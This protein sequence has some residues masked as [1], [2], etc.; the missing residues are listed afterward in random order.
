MSRQGRQLAEVGPD[1][2]VI[3]SSAASVTLI[4]YCDFECPYCRRATPVVKHLVARYA[5]GMRFVYRHFP[6]VDKHPAALQAAEA[7][8]AAGAQGRFWDMHDL[9]FANQ[10]ALETDDLLVYAERLGLDVAR[11]ATDLRV[12][13]YLDRIRMD[14]RSG[15][16]AGVRGTPTFYVNG[17]PFDEEQR[18]EAAIE[19]AL[20]NTGARGAL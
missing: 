11:V 7:A 6:L 18:L 5:A 4:A 13:R 19:A 17:Q 14:M 16:A 1:E 8:E 15:A 2:H 12:H 3:G 9:L 20:Q 10:E